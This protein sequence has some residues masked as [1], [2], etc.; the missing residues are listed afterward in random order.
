V[1]LDVEPEDDEEE[2]EEEEEEEDEDDA[3]GGDQP[4]YTGDQSD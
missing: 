1:I 3:L 4:G 2:E